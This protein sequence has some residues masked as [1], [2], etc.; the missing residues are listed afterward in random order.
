MGGSV[1]IV[2]SRSK[3]QPAHGAWAFRAR[4]HL[5]HVNM[6]AWGQFALSGLARPRAK[7]ELESDFTSSGTC[8]TDNAA[9]FSEAPQVS[10]EDHDKELDDRSLVDIYERI[11]SGGISV[12]QLESPVKREQ[13]RA[14]ADD[15]PPPGRPRK[16]R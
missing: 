11:S 7:R 8:G 3:P 5:G 2:A 6:L 10:E 13:N 9:N 4:P 1:A 12:E 16:V 15:R 14:K